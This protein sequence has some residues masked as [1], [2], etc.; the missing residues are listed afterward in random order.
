MNNL[1]YI[2]VKLFDTFEGISSLI[3]K[4]VIAS[5]EDEARHIIVNQLDREIEEIDAP[6]AGYDITNIK[7]VREL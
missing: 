7:F 1:Y 2:D 4:T 6:C 5:N 3:R